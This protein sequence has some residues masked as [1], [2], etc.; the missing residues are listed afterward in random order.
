MCT[1]NGRP[2]PR[3]PIAPSRAT[4]LLPGPLCVATREQAAAGSG[5]PR[6][7]RVGDVD[8]LTYLRNIRPGEASGA[9]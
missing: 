9:R 1:G 4:G 8:A 3:L 2:R 7:E 5:S 6:A